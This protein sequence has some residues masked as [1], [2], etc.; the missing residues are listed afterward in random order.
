MTLV[1]PTPDETTLG[2]PFAEDSSKLSSIV[3]QL[4]SVH[5]NRNKRQRRSVEEAGIPI[6]PIVN[7]MF[8][9]PSYLPPSSSILM[10]IQQIQGLH[11][12]QPI[13]QIQNLPL[14]MTPVLP[15]SQ[16]VT[17]PSQLVPGVEPIS[18]EQPPVDHTLQHP[19]V[20]QEIKPEIKSE[21]DGKAVTFQLCQGA[22]EQPMGDQ[23]EEMD[24][25]RVKDCLY[26]V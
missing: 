20:M 11:V 8:Q 24:S 2:S 23:D 21:V 1:V 7:D 17:Q 10:P 26:S 13:I 15:S 19:V 22:E 14:S 16:S 25:K 4:P 18:L 5:H 6:I 3:S 9:D 12:S